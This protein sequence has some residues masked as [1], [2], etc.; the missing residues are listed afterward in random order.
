[1]PDYFYSLPVELQEYI[2]DLRKS[3]CITRI[4]KGRIHKNNCRYLILLVSDLMNY[5]SDYSLDISNYINPQHIPSKTL[6]V[7]SH[8]VPWCQFTVNTIYN[9]KNFINNLCPLQYYLLMISLFELNQLSQ[10]LFEFTE[11]IYNGI[12][13]CSD[14]YQ[15]LTDLPSKLN[16]K[17][18]VSHPRWPRIDIQISPHI[19]IAHNLR[20]IQSFYVQLRCILRDA[21]HV[22]NMKNFHRLGRYI[23]QRVPNITRLIIPPDITDNMSNSIDLLTKIWKENSR[24]EFDEF[25][26]LDYEPIDFDLFDN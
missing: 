23:I 2:F 17:S 25:G 14:N 16:I 26:S 18:F 9:I 24:K 21:R 11:Y 12:K 19:N 1:M 10:L 5:H 15:G 22:Y 8:F 7:P 4:Y 20:I 3:I 13:I 6:S